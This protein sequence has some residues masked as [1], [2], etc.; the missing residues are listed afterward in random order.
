MR[1][2]SFDVGTKNLGM[3][4]GEFVGANRVFP[5]RF[6]HWEKLSLGTNQL[7]EAC[8][9]M[10]SE[11]ERRPWLN[12]CDWILVENQIDDIV[13]DRERRSQGLVYKAGRMKAV[14]QAICTYFYTKRFPHESCCQIVNVSARNKLKVWEGMGLGPRPALPFNATH[15]KKGKPKK[16]TAHCSNKL[17]AEIQTAAL[18]RKGI[19]ATECDPKWL[20]FIESLEKRDDVADAFLQAAYWVLH[21][22]KWNGFSVAQRAPEITSIQGLEEGLW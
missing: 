21:K 3:W 9:C 17:L 13:M 14:G 4:V 2:A 20:A 15:T 10:V 8:E 12:E 7:K 11:F 22:E 18:L 6:L 19:D 1:I 16:I 5:F